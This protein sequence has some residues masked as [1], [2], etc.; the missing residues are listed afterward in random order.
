MKVIYGHT[1]SIYIQIDS[2]EESKKVC[3]EVNAHVQKFFPNVMGLETHPVQ[4]EFEKYYSTLGIGYTKNRNAGFI[5]WKDG[6]HLDKEEFIVTGFSMKRI[7]ESPMSKEF[8]TELLQKWASGESERHIVDFCKQKYND[9]KKGRIPMASIIKR[10]RLRNSLENYKSI[11]GGI[12]GVC[13][14]NQHISPNSYI[15]D[16]FIYMKCGS[17]HGAQYV[18]LPNGKERKATYVSF[19]EM[20]EITTDYVPDWDSYAETLVKKAKPIFKAMDWD[21]KRITVDESQKDL[22]EWF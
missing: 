4:L 12:A 21:I 9:V 18:M 14:Y 7:S 11:A 5:S 16:S 3:E 19:K 10:G 1:D 17:I 8:Q 2:I 6:K 20:K 13:Y 15:T 22:T